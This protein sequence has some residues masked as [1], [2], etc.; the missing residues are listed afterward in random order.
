M[1]I[2]HHQ[3]SCLIA[4]YIAHT[5]T[6]TRARSIHSWRWYNFQF[7][8][9]HVSLPANSINQSH[10]VCTLLILNI[11]THFNPF[12][13]WRYSTQ[14]SIFDFVKKKNKRNDWNLQQIFI[15]SFG[16]VVGEG[17][18]EHQTASNECKKWTTAFNRRP[19]VDG[20]LSKNVYRRDDQQMQN[21]FAFESIQYSYFNTYIIIV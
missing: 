1:R 21:K 19:E 11:Y 2:I 6:C 15:R 12:E 13:G 7:M 20:R 9:S 4:K 5:R 16:I 3:P 17:R 14:K 10:N 18:V 8:E